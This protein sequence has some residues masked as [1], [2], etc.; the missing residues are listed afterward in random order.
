MSL[1]SL[2]TPA[3]MRAHR[4]RWY[5]Y[6]GGQDANG[7]PE[8]IPHVSTMRGQWGYDVACS[9]GWETKTGGGLRRYVEDKLFDHRHEA[10]TTDAVR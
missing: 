2:L 10:Q 4:A 6:T 8:R 1:N 7:Q 5:V 3:T 9:C